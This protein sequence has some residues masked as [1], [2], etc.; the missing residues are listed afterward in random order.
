MIHILVGYYES[1]CIR[2]MNQ[3][4]NKPVRKSVRVRQVCPVGIWVLTGTQLHLL[5]LVHH[6]DR[7]CRQPKVCGKRKFYFVVNSEISNLTQLAAW[8]QILQFNFPWIIRRFTDR[9][10]LLRAWKSAERRD[11]E[12]L[13]SSSLPVS[14]VEV[15][16]ILSYATDKTQVERQRRN[17]QKRSSWSAG[18]SLP[19]SHF[20]T[21]THEALRARFY[22]REVVFN[23][24]NAYQTKQYTP[25]KF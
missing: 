2:W 23:P 21:C 3:S 22:H 20:Y 5:K 17:I 18:G 16:F 9:I 25:S 12:R 13:S 15:F 24:T 14:V 8:N 10:V 6:L 19:F 11:H 1:S 4:N 7:R